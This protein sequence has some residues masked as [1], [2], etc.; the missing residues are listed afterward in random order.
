MKAAIKNPSQV[1]KALSDPNRLTLLWNLAE[2][3]VADCVGSI[4]E[5]CPVDLSVISRHLSV[6]RK[7]GLVSAERMGKEVRYALN[8]DFIVKFLRSLADS[9][10]DCCP[11]GSECCGPQK[12]VSKR[13][14]KRRTP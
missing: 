5:C 3:R 1:F 9:I 10:E 2:C 6:L 7:A 8:R 11:Q 12:K 13:P 4:A 14:K